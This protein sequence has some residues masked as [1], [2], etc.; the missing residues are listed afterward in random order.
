MVGKFNFFNMRKKVFWIEVL[1]VV[2]FFDVDEEVIKFLF[3]YLEF[4]LE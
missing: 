4:C 3:E 2:G 1:E